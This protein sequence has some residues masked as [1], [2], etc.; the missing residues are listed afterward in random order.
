MTETPAASARRPAVGFVFVTSAL[1][2]LGWGIISPVLPGL[3]TEFEGGDAAAGAH[4][5][6][7][8]LGSF[9]VMQF[10][11]APLLGVSRIVVIGHGRS[12][13]RAIRNAIRSVKEFSEHRTAEQIEKGIKNPQITQL[14]T[15]VNLRVSV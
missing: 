13:A 6:G 8:I 5:Y 12:N 4:M 10:L 14:P 11:G 15:D 9:A 7:W 3:I 1:I 2:V